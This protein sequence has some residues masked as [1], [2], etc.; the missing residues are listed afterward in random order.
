MAKGIPGRLP[1]SE[2][3]CSES[4]S[5]LGLCG[6][7]YQRMR[8]RGS[9]GPPRTTGQRFWAK[10]N[11][12]ETCWLWTGSRTAEG[13]GTFAPTRRTRIGAHRYAYIISVGPIPDG[14]T[15]DHLCRNPGCVN[16]AHL[17]P[18]TM[19]ENQQRGAS[20]W[21][22]NA[23]KTHCKRGHPFDSVNTRINADGRRQCRACDRLRKTQVK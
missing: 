19:W 10:V 1:C 20:P 22:L 7:H 17:E 3:G 16:P 11:K 21:A 5:A 13:Y 18:M 23:A 12:T 4:S 15:L 8:R 2:E 6:M 9:T 14:L